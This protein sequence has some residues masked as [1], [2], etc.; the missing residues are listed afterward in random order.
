M[1]VYRLKSKLI[2]LKL[3]N[4]NYLDSTF[5]VSEFSSVFLSASFSFKLE[6]LFLDSSCFELSCSFVE[7]SA[8]DSLF[9]FFT[10]L[11]VWVVSSS[12]LWLSIEEVLVCFSEE[13]S[14][15]FCSFVSSL[16][17]FDSSC[18]FL[19]SDSL[20]LS[21]FSA[22]DCPSSNFEFLFSWLSE[23]FSF[24]LF[25]S[26]LVSFFLFLL[27]FPQ[28]IYCHLLVDQMVRL[29]FCLYYLVVFLV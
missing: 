21:E 13:S 27:K 15:C 16:L 7:P 8:L 2:I 9:L 28:K 6:V 3:I 26:S 19:V 25:F 23:L 18:S 14:S 1:F 4:I 10:S 24:S 20:F 5:S 11:S 17:D 12:F 22:S 29:L